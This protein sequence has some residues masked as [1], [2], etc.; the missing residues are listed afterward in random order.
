MKLLNFW[1]WLHGCFKFLILIG[2]LHLWVFIYSIFLHNHHYNIYLTFVKWPPFIFLYM[3]KNDFGKLQYSFYGVHKPFDSCSDKAKSIKTLL[4]DEGTPLF[5]HENTTKNIVYMKRVNSACYERRSRSV[6][7]F[8]RTSV[9]VCVC[10][11]ERE[12][13][14][15]RQSYCEPCASH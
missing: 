1:K 11:R 8:A 5:W 9:C 4:K 6:S 3:D 12:R 2:Q 14:R 7:F 10:V 13:E 15:E